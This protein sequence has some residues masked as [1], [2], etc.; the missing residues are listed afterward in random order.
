[1]LAHRRRAGCVVERLGV[2]R[3][4]GGLEGGSRLAWDLLTKVWLRTESVCE[5]EQ[6][7]W[8]KDTLEGVL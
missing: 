2:G 8:R 7:G 3:V 4:R 5:R 1:M 6:R